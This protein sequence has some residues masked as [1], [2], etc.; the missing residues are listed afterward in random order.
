MAGFRKAGTRGSL[1]YLWQGS[2]RLAL[3]AAN[4]TCGRVQKG[5]HSRLLALP[6]A[7]FRKAGTIEAASLTCGRV[8]KGWH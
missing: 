4:L 5:W 1:P 6:V 7:G 8:Q 2:E 3:E